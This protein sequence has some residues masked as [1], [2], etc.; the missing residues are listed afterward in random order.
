MVDEELLVKFFSLV[1]AG[2]GSGMIA[3]LSPTCELSSF[4]FQQPKQLLNHS[5]YSC[6]M[7]CLS[8]LSFIVE[9]TNVAA[10]EIFGADGGSS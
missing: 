9:N 1:A 4:F 3:A 10:P 6:S 2:V 7:A 8:G 5:I